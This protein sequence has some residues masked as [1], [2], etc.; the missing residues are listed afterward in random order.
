MRT[1]TDPSKPLFE[2]IMTDVASIGEHAGVLQAILHKQLDG[3]IVRNVLS[4]Q[5]VSAAIERLDANTERRKFPMF[6]ALD[7]APYTVGEPI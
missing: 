7:D 6:K 4:P 5:A 2:F 3:I 1:R